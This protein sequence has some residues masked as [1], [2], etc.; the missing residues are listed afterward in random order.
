MGR[1]DIELRDAMAGALTAAKVSGGQFRQ[2]MPIYGDRLGLAYQV[3]R[4]QQIRRMGRALAVT[5][6]VA[7]VGGAVAAVVAER[8]I[9]HRKGAEVGE[10]AATPEEVTQSEAAFTG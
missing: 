1:R 5:A 10:E 7:A 4:G 9:A 2:L 6:V 3:M 8:F